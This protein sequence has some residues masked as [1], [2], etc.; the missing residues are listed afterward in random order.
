M[1][2]VQGINWNIDPGKNM[3]ANN[4]LINALIF[5]TRSCWLSDIIMYIIILSSVKYFTSISTGWQCT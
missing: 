2:S 4:D 5:Q 1:T 3:K